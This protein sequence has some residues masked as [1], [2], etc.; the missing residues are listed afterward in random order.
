MVLT[1]FSGSSGSFR[2]Y[3]D[4]GTGLG[5]TRGQ[6]TETTITDLVASG[7]GATAS[8]A[9]VTVGSA[10]GHYRGEPSA[11]RYRLEMVDLSEPSRVTLDGR[12]IDRRS[13]GSDAPG[14]SYRAS[15][16][17]VVVVTAPLSTARTFTVLASGTRAVSRSEPPTGP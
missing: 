9:R 11:V 13:A 12:Q 10:R 2:L 14:W 3:G 5:Y 1:V 8:T 4:S 15:T 16:A 17:T 6:S 7:A